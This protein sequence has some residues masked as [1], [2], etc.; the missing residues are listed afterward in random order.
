MSSCFW[1]LATSRIFF[2]SWDMIL[3]FMLRES[4]IVHVKKRKSPVKQAALSKEH[5]GE[6]EEKLME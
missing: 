6:A 4:K 1:V 5:K 2:E 3:L